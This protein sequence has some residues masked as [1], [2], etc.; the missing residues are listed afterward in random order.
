MSKPR[1]TT[2]KPRL[3]A[4]PDRVPTLT[5]TPG[6]TRRERGRPWRRLRAAILSNHPL[7][8]HCL[9]CGRVTPATEVDHRVP[10]SVGGTDDPANL[11]PVCTDC[12]RA[13]SARD[14]ARR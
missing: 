12:H 5:G 6:A 2:L 3:S 14:A 4:L 10:L 9:A 13:K 1:L 7:C 11:D 8:V